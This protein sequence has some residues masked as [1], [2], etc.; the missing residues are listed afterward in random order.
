[1]SC[2][3]N[4]EAFYDQYCI[5]SVSVVFMKRECVPSPLAAFSWLMVWK[6]YL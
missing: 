3:Q 4:V 2:Q 1:M 5:V 6:I